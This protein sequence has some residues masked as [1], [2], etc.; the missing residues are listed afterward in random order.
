MTDRWT[1]FSYVWVTFYTYTFDIYFH[2]NKI[3]I[4]NAGTH[5][6]CNRHNSIH[7]L[8][9]N[10][11]RHMHVEKSCY[12]FSEVQKGLSEP[13]PGVGGGVVTR[14][15]LLNAFAAASFFKAMTLLEMKSSPS[16]PSDVFQCLASGVL[17]PRRCMAVEITH[18]TWNVGNY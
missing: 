14:W 2:R 15:F 1:T 9:R 3:K 17:D 13:V 12:L 5:Y 8:K 10:C 18:L 6:I 11:E 16:N 4:P 7:I